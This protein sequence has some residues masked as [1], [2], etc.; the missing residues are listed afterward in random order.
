VHYDFVII[1]LQKSAVNNVQ[2]CDFSKESGIYLIARREHTYGN[3]G[4]KL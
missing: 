2:N 3:R 4:N 1:E